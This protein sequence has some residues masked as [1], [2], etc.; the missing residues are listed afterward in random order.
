MHAENRI[1]NKIKY[2]L[3]KVQ[4]EV[5]ELEWCTFSET[6]KLSINLKHFTV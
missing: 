1:S 6:H 3:T 2:V 4:N 5:T